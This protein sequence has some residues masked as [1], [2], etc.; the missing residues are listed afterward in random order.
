VR[1]GT[2]R[3]IP[4][5][6]GEQ[7]TAPQKQQTSTAISATP[8]TLLDGVSIT[9]LTPDISQ[10]L[11]LAPSTRGVVVTDVDPASLAAE[12]GLERGDVIEQ[13]DHK[14]VSNTAELQEAVHASGKKPTLL[15]VN[16]GGSTQF[17]VI[18]PD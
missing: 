12:A 2:E 9:E 16:R 18:E 11:H 10:Q 5:T 14:P 15:L 8:A 6:L 4:V 7:P 17:V 3:E 1:N 13:L